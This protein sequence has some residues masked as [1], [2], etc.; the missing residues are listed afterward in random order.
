MKIHKI[1][2]FKKTSNLNGCW[3]KFNN[4]VK[5]ITGFA[6]V[7]LFLFSSNNLQAQIPCID[8]EANEWGEKDEPLNPLTQLQTYSYVEDDLIGNDDDAFHTGAKDFLPLGYGGNQWTETS[9]LAKGDIMNAAAFI[10]S[11]IG[12]DEQIEEGCPQIGGPVD[13]DL[14]YLS[15]HTYL[16][17]AGDRESNN[18]VA[19]IGFWF[20]LDGTEPV[21]K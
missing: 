10:I 1:T 9:V 2:R 16:F 21:K 19:Q 8:G 3:L 20:F 14:V 18:G 15:D 12:I 17:F 4:Y 6:V 5:G 11:G 7:M 13:D